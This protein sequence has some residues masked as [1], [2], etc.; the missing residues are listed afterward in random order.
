[1]RPHTDLPLALNHVKKERRDRA[2]E[3]ADEPVRYW[4]LTNVGICA[5][6]R[7]TLAS[8]GLRRFCAAPGWLLTSEALQA[9]H[10]FD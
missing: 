2:F 10:D 1:M 8:D 4:F 7:L 9:R 6:A 3:L 5:A